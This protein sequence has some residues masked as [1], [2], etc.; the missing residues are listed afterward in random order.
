MSYVIRSNSENLFIDTPIIGLPNDIIFLTFESGGEKYNGPYISQPS[1][2]EVFQQIYYNYGYTSISMWALRFWV[3]PVN[4]CYIKSMVGPNGTPS[5]NRS[6]ILY[7]PQYYSL[8][9]QGFYRILWS[10]YHT[11]SGDGET[12]ETFYWSKNFLVY[13]ASTPPEYSGLYEMPG[14][15]PVSKYYQFNIPQ[16]TAENLGGQIFLNLSKV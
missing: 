8:R 16:R 10:P 4:N 5:W 7:D 2:S 12:V 6:I 11:Y 14:S 9:E 15:I 1:G 3:N 13:P